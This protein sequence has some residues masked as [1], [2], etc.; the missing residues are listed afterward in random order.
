[1]RYFPYKILISVAVIFPLYGICI[2]AEELCPSFCDCDFWFGLRRAACTGRHLYS[3]HTDVPREIQALDLSNNAISNVN[4]FDLAKAGLTKLKYLNL[5]TNGINDVGLFAFDGLTNLTILDLSRNHLY[6]LLPETFAKN[7]NLRLLRLSKNSFKDHVPKLNC[8]GLTELSMD[9]CKIRHIPPDTF[10]GLRHL[11]NLDIS[12]NMMIQL[13]TAIF[14]PMP[15]L[16]KLSLAGN[17]W[18]CNNVMRDLQVYLKSRRIEHDRICS[19]TMPKMFEKMIMKPPVIIKSKTNQSTS[20]SQPKKNTSIEQ[21]NTSEPRVC[22]SEKNVINEIWFL[23]A[24]LILGSATTLVFTYLWLTTKISCCNN[25]RNDPQRVSLLD[26]F[27]TP[28]IPNE[29]RTTS[30]PGTPPP[31]YRDV[32]LHPQYYR[33][34]PSIISLSDT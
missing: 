19:S 14:R 32:M 29:D 34:P 1:M 6:F 22:N 7:Y 23:L 15:Q 2:L 10:T 24:G 28:Y 18:S 27:D 21:K 26:N 11:R 8:N 33:S 5:S 16:R 3:I 31:P 17:S 9:S 13:G 4:N 25:S 30:C 12:N 20:W